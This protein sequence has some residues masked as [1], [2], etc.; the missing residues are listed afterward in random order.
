VNKKVTVR[1]HGPAAEVIVECTGAPCLTVHADR[2]KLERLTFRRVGA[3]QPPLAAVDVPGGHLEMEAC[4]VYSSTGPGLAVY[5]PHARATLSHCVVANCATAGIA[6]SD[7][8][9][10]SIKSC[11][12]TGN[13]GGPIVLQQAGN[14]ED[15]GNFK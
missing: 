3:A 11:T 12:L 15:V 5:G 8:A 1:G 13:F 6:V 14:V 7:K 2:V 4:V 9:R 10:A